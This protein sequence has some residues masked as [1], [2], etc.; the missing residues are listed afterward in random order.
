M[1]GIYNSFN[2]LIFLYVQN[3]HSKTQGEYIKPSN[4]LPLQLSISQAK[5]SSSLPVTIIAV[6]SNGSPT[7]L[8]CIV[9]FYSHRSFLVTSYVNYTIYSLCKWNPTPIRKYEVFSYIL[10]ASC[11][12]I[13]SCTSSPSFSYST[14]TLQSYCYVSSVWA[15]LSCCFFGFSATF[16]CTTLP[17]LYVCAHVHH[18]KIVFTVASTAATFCFTIPPQHFCS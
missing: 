14:L 11:K 2:F 10:K 17:K 12:L 15:M 4:F 13:P 3:F 5:S 7:L 1:V 8:S 18:Q 9:I 6:I 16:F